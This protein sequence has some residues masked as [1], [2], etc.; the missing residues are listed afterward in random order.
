MLIEHE[1]KNKRTKEPRT[2]AINI[3]GSGALKFVIKVAEI[4][5]NNDRTM[6]IIFP[7]FSF[8]WKI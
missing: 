2:N 6:D 1:P 5:N 3:N 7:F 4:N 8:F